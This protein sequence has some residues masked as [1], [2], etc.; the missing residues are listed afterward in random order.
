MFLPCLICLFP[1]SLWSQ[2]KDSK[3]LNDHDLPI[4]L[5]GVTHKLTAT[6][7][8]WDRAKENKQGCGVAASRAQSLLL[9]KSS[10]KA[11]CYLTSNFQK[12]IVL[13][14]EFLQEASFT[15]TTHTHTHTHS[16]RW[17]KEVRKGGGFRAFLLQLVYW[18]VLNVDSTTRGYKSLPRRSAR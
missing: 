10:L 11:P 12:K 2:T 8:K 14:M 4:S 16:E 7:A 15:H 3:T 9:N 17:H 1:S 18:H 5:E 6:L 13:K